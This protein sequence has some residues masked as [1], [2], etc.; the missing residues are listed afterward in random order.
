MHVNTD[1][2]FSDAKVLYF[3][4]IFTKANTTVITLINIF[5]LPTCH[6]LKSPDNLLKYIS[7]FQVVDIPTGQLCHNH[8][9]RTKVGL[10]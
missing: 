8:Q 1:L 9:S 5:E 3:H 6:T 10:Y 2:C 4:Q 7:I